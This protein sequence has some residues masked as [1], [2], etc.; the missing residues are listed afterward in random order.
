MSVH[1]ETSHSLVQEA[2]KLTPL[3]AFCREEFEAHRLTDYDFVAAF[4]VAYLAVR[5]P[6]C[7]LGGKLKLP[8][9]SC[10]C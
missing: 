3:I 5:R 2:E 1:I 9:M 10:K 6:K 7:W 8:A 4:I